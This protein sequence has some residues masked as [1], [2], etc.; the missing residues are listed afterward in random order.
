MELIDKLKITDRLGFIHTA[1]IKHFPVIGL[2]IAYTER[3]ERIASREYGR[4]IPPAG[5]DDREWEEWD[6]RFREWVD[7]AIADLTNECKSYFDKK[8]K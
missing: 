1:V 6:G 7:G 5:D 8:L 3:D 4:M 2:S